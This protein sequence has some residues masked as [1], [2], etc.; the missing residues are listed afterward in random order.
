MTRVAPPPAAAEPLVDFDR[1]LAAIRL[2]RRWA[3]VG[4]L[5]GL[6]LGL[7]LAFVVSPPPPASARVLIARAEDRTSDRR[8]LMATDV[9]LCR[10]EDVASRAASVLGESPAAVLARYSC[11][12]NSANVLSVSARGSAAADAERTAQAVIDAVA[13]SNRARRQQMV[14]GMTNGLM[15]RRAGLE[16]SVAR[17]VALTAATGNG[18]PGDGAPGN[19]ASGGDPHVSSFASVRNGLVA[20]I[21]DLSERV[22]ELR[23]EYAAADAGTQVVDPA[24]VLLQGPLRRVGVNLGAGLVLGV[25]GALVCAALAG[26]VRDR[27]VRRTDVAAALRAPVLL[28]IRTPARLGSAP[29]GRARRASAANAAVSSVASLVSMVPGPVALLELRCPRAAADLAAGVAVALGTERRLVLAGN[30]FQAMTARQVSMLMSIATGLP[31]AGTAQPW[32]GVGT[33]SRRTGWLDLQQLGRRA[34]LLVRAGRATAT[35]LAEVARDLGHAEI[36]VLGIILVDAD[37]HDSTGGATHDALYDVIRR[38]LGY[39][40]PGDPGSG[41]PPAGWAPEPGY[42]QVHPP[43]CGSKV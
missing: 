28:D 20:E 3:A 37:P 27:P 7:A 40:P 1:L 16:R 33:L 8:E 42:H 24:H 23:L 36:D 38:H 30:L 43:A 9:A 6:G 4:V 41:G 22:L 39:G 29:W 12:S 34:I 18:A 17:I 11:V 5:V 19:G 13:A 10:G 35:T 15:A 25:G 21:A 32:L 31:V 2:R 26:I 14:D